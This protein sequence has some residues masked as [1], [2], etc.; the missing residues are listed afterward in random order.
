MSLV[1][2]KA[3]SVAGRVTDEA[4]QPVAGC[5]VQIDFADLLD[6]NGQETSN[7]FT[8]VWGHLPGSIG[9][10][11]TDGEG[12]FVLDRLPDLA[13]FRLAIQRPE[14]DLT[15]LG[16]YTATVDGLK[17]P[18]GEARWGS[19]RSFAPRNQDGQP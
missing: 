8:G 2:P 10:A 11:L 9:L 3:A 1:F 19:Q 7:L 5:K 12:R 13:T 6:D 18:T 16:V 17:I 14:F 15:C 4:G